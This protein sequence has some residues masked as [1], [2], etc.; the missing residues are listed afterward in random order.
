MLRCVDY[1]R[2]QDVTSAHRG[3]TNEVI[4]LPRLSVH[5]V[6]YGDELFE[7]GRRWILRLNEESIVLINDI[8]CQFFKSVLGVLYLIAE[9]PSTVKL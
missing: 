5:E 4:S 9:A 2:V 1:L 8:R 3:F 6:I 7:N